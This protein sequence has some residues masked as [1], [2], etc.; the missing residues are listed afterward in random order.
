MKH[1]NCLTEED[2]FG[3]ELANDWGFQGK[4]PIC[5][6]CNNPMRICFATT[7]D[8]NDDFSDRKNLSRRFAFFC[9]CDE[10]EMWRQ[11]LNLCFINKIPI[12]VKDLS[13][14][15]KGR[16]DRDKNRSEQDNE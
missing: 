5:S 8:W 1:N 6:F 11:K 16:Y 13:D 15:Y 4:W 14:I 7:G 9:E 10:W 12:T 2:E 3:K